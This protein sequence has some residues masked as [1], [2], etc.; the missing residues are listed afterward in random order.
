MS[1]RLSILF[2]C[3]QPTDHNFFFIL[4]KFDALT[5]AIEN[6]SDQITFL[7]ISRIALFWRVVI[8]I[9][10]GWCR[11]FYGGPRYSF[12]LSNLVVYII[13]GITFYL[14]VKLSLAYS[15][16]LNPSFNWPKL[17]MSLFNFRALRFNS[18]FNLSRR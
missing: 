3:S 8:F 9:F 2:V 14:L 6:A 1:V 12:Y 7:T 16:L 17:G 4:M 11:V 5:N 10:I 13:V 15:F 18:K